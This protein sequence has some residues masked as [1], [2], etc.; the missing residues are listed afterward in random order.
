MSSLPLATVTPAAPQSRAL[1]AANAYEAGEVRLATYPRAITV[2]LTALL[3]LAPLAFGAV[4]PWAWGAIGV[5]AAALLV[6]WTIHSL[7]H[8][9]ATIFISPLYLPAVLF[10]AFGMFQLVGRS[11]LDPFSTR[12]SLLKLGAD[13]VLFFLAGQLWSRASSGGSRSSTHTDHRARLVPAV[14]LYSFGLAVFAILQFFSSNGLLYWTVRPRWGGWIFGPYVNHNHYAG[15][16]EMLIPIS[17]AW[18]ISET[19][20]SLRSPRDTSSTRRSRDVLLAFLVLVP[21]ASVLL[22]GSRGGR[23]ALLAEAG[24]LSAI[25]LRRAAGIHRRTAAGAFLVLAASL[26]CFFL[27]DPGGLTERLTSPASLSQASEATLGDRLIVARDS[28][29]IVRDHPW[30][31]TGLGSF[32]AVYPGYRS[33]PT[34]LVWDH[35]HND[36]LEAVAD[37]GLAG[38]VLIAAALILFF[39]LAFTNLGERLRTP[40]GWIELGAA[41]GCIGLLIHGLSD[42]NL[43]IPANAAWF[44]VCAAVATSHHNP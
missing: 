38:A 37:T 4:Q 18:V 14:A 3:F 13:L 6:A 40:L 7:R 36:C 20:G 42:F 16:M 35:A 32:E 26:L 9:E 33:F 22:S 27:L 28:L 41:L 25:L 30:L 24:I 15:L 12:E 1:P 43:H 17:A 29:R 39:T 8:H 34:D 10:F 23:I 5:T 44:A 2:S 31:G 21:I 11:S 19:S